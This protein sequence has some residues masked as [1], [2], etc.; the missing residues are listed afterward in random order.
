MAGNPFHTELE[1][2]FRSRRVRVTKGEHTYKGWL[3]VWHY[4]HPAVVL[5]D[6]VRDGTDDVAEVMI[7][8]PDTVERVEPATTIESVDPRD[9]S[10]SPYTQRTFDTQDFLE[11]SRTLRQR[12]YIKQFPIV[13]PTDDTSSSFEIVSGHKRVEAA[14]EAGLETIAVEVRDLSDWE[15]L[16]IFVDEHIPI[17]DSEF[18]AAGN[19][20]SGW[21]SSEAVEQ[22]LDAL[23]D[24]W[25]ESQLREH[26][27][28]RWFL[29]EK[30]FK[31]DDPE[32]EASEGDASDDDTADD[33]TADDDS[34]DD[35]SPD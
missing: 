23:R 22:A 1:E 11:F 35:D 17:T 6:A 34:A 4:N 5:A 2:Q 7:T 9:L 14:T 3:R 31:D 33:D 18:G 26:R 30:S 29:D 8:D 24:D 25:S 32:D 16:E 21:Y 15:A 20:G 10:P 12:G 27:T 28:L 13:R 19:E